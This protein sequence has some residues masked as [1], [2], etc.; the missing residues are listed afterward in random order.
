[1]NCLVT[2]AGGFVG[3]HL[4]R[5]LKAR[6]HWVRGVDR[7]P[8]RFSPTAADEF[9]LGDL[10]DPRAVD[11][12]FCTVVRRAGNDEP[13][14]RFDQ[15]YH[16]SADMGGADYLFTGA[17]DADIL[18]RNALMQ[19][20]MLHAAQRWGAT[21][22]FSASSACVYPQGN[23]TTP[24]QPDCREET[25]YP[26]DP[27]SEYGWEK[28]FGERCCLAFSRQYGLDVKIA[29]FHAIV[30]PEGAWTGG[31]EKVFAATCR[32]IAQLPATG[33]TI[34]IYGDGEQTRSFLLV[35]DCLDAIETLM[36]L[37][38]DDHGPYN[39]GSEELVSIN[40]LAWRIA[41][42][43]GK[44]LDGIYHDP[45]PLGVRGR[46]STNDRLTAATGWTPKHTLDQT[47]ARTY[48]WIAEQVERSR[49]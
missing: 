7:K 12:A 44:P 26:A 43:A 42:F 1:M 10:T 15:V 24:D 17:H 31:R 3:S 6:G 32:K 19:L 27:D 18:Y 14:P 34:R 46:R 45:G 49:P 13:R 47:I 35:D 20:H 37:P 5:R 4:V 28:L 9:L 41:A 16:L 23:Q 21:Q 29:R 22:Y 48:P 40:Q 30:G 33:G 2:G 39:V 25:V 36:R 8:P 11:N 38:A